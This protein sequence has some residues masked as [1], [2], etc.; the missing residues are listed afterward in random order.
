MH[1]RST[2]NN[3]MALRELLLWATKAHKFYEYQ[4]FHSLHCMLQLLY[5]ILP[6]IIH[7]SEQLFLNTDQNNYSKTIFWS[8]T[9]SIIDIKFVTLSW[10][11]LFPCKHWYFLANLN[12][13]EIFIKKYPTQQILLPNNNYLS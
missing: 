1:Q 2:S 10:N 7:L 4:N 6:Y 11:L 8:V 13:F 9:L 5:E 3:V 12:F